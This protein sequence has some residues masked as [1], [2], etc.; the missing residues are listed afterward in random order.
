MS[1]TLDDDRMRW[2]I[3]E[4]TKR[5]SSDS[6][7]A[8]L[9][10]TF[11]KSDLTSYSGLKRTI[12]IEIAKL[13]FGFDR[14]DTT[15]IIFS[16]NLKQIHIP[17]AYIFISPICY[18]PV[19]CYGSGLQSYEG[20]YR[21][22]LVGLNKLKNIYEAHYSDTW[23]AFVEHT[24]TRVSQFK[25]NHIIFGDKVKAEGILKS[26]PDIFNILLQINWFI[27][28]VAIY[29]KHR[30]D[31][32]M[33][34]YQEVFKKDLHIDNVFMGKLMNDFKSTS[35][36]EYL[37]TH[38]NGSIFGQKIIPVC[39][40]QI[41]GNK[42]I[43]SAIPEIN[44]MEKLNSLTVNMISPSFPLFSGWF[45]INADD[46]SISTIIASNDRLKRRF[47][48]AKVYS[49]I[50]KYLDCAKELTYT[51]T[52][53]IPDPKERQRYGYPEKFPHYSLY[54]IHGKIDTLT[55]DISG[56]IFSDRTVCIISENVGF[57]FADIPYFPLSYKN[58][59]DPDVF[60]KY[61]FELIYALF[62][63]NSRL[64][65]IHGDMSPANTT[66]REVTKPSVNNPSILYIIKDVGYI[67]PFCEYMSLI[68]FSGVASKPTHVN[69]KVPDRIMR[70]YAGIPNMNVN[71]E[72][73][74]QI[75]K[76]VDT[77]PTAAWKLLTA[78]DILQFI[79]FVKMRI[80]KITHNPD[81]GVL[82]LIDCIY[83]KAHTFVT[84]NILDI[85][86]N[87]DYID[88]PNLQ[89]LQSCFSE[90][91]ADQSDYTIVD[92][93]NYDNDIKYKLDKYDNF[94]PYMKQWKGIKT[95]GTLYEQKDKQH[96]I[97][98]D[99]RRDL[100]KRE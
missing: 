64:N 90:F 97:H 20:E 2:Y 26:Y 12:P 67:F 82:N 75:Q 80:R 18:E 35:E 51:N 47:R 43:L 17:Y 79:T 81:K 41:D 42:L 24:K 21:P 95:D 61:M 10:N 54:T 88:Y 48:R 32:T 70:K 60:S 68:D 76:I 73:F 1:T 14:N 49:N 83:Q 37:L 72:T 39:L 52:E 22:Y 71:D 85:K 96:E 44:I 33:G 100:E 87:E 84:K 3:S 19:V 13:Y 5:F 45:Y 62:C 46:K 34:F 6:K 29:K 65:L 25:Y 9:L 98:I 86:T 57:R 38:I 63:M 59:Y 55:K 74:K 53:M 58:I 11:L 69:D 23:N 7:Y 92:V 94:P 27:E 16:A 28:L 40:S 4:Y 77:Y 15:T 30:L 91:V 8:K 50:L 99:C 36:L 78:M 66:L 31:A 56:D 93:Y 89:I